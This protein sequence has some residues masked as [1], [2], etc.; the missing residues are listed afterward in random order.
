MRGDLPARLGVCLGNSSAEVRAAAVEAVGRAVSN[1]AVLAAIA[2][3]PAP[4]L[5]DASVQVRGIG[6]LWG[7]QPA[8]TGP[9]D[10]DSGAC[11]GEISARCCLGYYGVRS[12]SPTK[13]R[14]QP[15]DGFSG[16]N[17]RPM[18]VSCSRSR[19]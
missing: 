5:V 13:T 19:Q 4:D 7:C 18:T 12:V 16:Q 17:G 14:R 1:P 15:L 2:A 6:A 9:C 8:V 10:A 11:D 3:S